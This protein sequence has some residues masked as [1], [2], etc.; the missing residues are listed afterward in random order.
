MP[1]STHGSEA[2]TS[3]TR[4]SV[5]CFLCAAVLL[6]PVLSAAPRPAGNGEISKEEFVGYLLRD[7]SID[8]ANGML[9]ARAHYTLPRSML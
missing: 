7:E 9:Q 2:C 6:A 3:L 5:L 4:R 1:N 8:E